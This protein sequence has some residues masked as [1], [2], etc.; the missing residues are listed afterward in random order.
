M[1]F[2]GIA[3][4]PRRI[5]DYPDIYWSWNFV[6]SVGAYLSFIGLLVFLL[7]I[8]Y[9]MKDYIKIVNFGN[10]YLIHITPELD[11]VVN[12]SYAYKN[13]YILSSYDIFFGKVSN[14]VYS[15][16]QLNYLV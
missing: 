16:F 4:M 2:L 9:M 5:S 10:N 14:I 3:G 6:A 11:I 13:L 15:F 12:K 7:L 1:H 8:Y